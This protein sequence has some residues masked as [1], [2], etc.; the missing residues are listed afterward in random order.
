M[1][2]TD[3]GVRKEFSPSRMS[4]PREPSPARSHLPR[5]RRI[6]ATADRAK[7]SPTGRR[8][9]T[10]PTMA[11]AASKRRARS[12]CATSWEPWSGVRLDGCYHGPFSASNNI[13]SGVANAPE[14]REVRGS[15]AL[16]RR[17]M[18]RPIRAELGRWH[19]PTCTRSA[20]QSRLRGRPV[21][22]PRQS[23][24][25]TFARR[26]VRVLKI[27]SAEVL[28]VSSPRRRIRVELQVTGYR[29]G[30][31]YRPIPTAPGRRPT[32]RQ[33]PRGRAREDALFEVEIALWQRRHRGGQ[34]RQPVIREM[35]RD[36]RY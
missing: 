4:H 1:I 23:D 16:Y 35:P 20:T 25:R 22:R 2:A 17:L 24:V 21:N 10:W 14:N 6:T 31:R 26:D 12:G 33:P 13:A 18:T 36:P 7:L 19:N 29:V 32:I 28:F 30:G 15:P 11:A 8:T 27:V 5:N 34:L 9:A 3:H